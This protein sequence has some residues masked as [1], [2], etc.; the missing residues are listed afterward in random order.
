ML[1]SQRLG[2]VGAV[3]EFECDIPDVARNTVV[4]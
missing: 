1:V 3:H 4:E 2:E